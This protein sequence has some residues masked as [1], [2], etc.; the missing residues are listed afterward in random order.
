[1]H[2]VLTGEKGVG[3]TA[4]VRD[5][6]V[7]LKAWG[8]R[9]FGFYTEKFSCG[10]RL[11]NVGGGPP[12]VLALTEPPKESAYCTLVGKY[13]FVNESV[14]L[15]LHMLR[16]PGDLLVVDEVGHWEALGGGFARAIDF[17]N[18]SEV[19]HSLIVVRRN[20]LPSIIERYRREPMV[21]EVTGKNHKVLVDAIARRFHD[22]LVNEAL[23][24]H[25]TQ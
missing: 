8:H 18:S 2:I 21:I 7:E 4:L 19:R 15:G 3:K 16:W 12:L 25:L 1:M 23:E 11:Q 5:L 9:P 20:I 13:Y 14:R 22:L 24:E 6:V 17:I 10:L